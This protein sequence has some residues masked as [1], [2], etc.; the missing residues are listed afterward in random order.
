MQYVCSIVSEIF[1]PALQMFQK[2]TVGV[3]SYWNNLTRVVIEIFLLLRLDVF[4]EVPSSSNKNEFRKSSAGL[5]YTRQNNEWVHP[6]DLNISKSV[7]QFLW[8]LGQL[9]FCPCPYFTPNLPHQHPSHLKGTASH[10]QKYLVLLIAIFHL[11]SFRGF[12]ERDELN[13]LYLLISNKLSSRR[14][15]NSTCFIAILMLQRCNFKSILVF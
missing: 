5:S 12:G 11:C 6:V 2:L 1:P 4:L 9:T 14:L 15:Q 8:C 7:L 10:N 13:L 3:L